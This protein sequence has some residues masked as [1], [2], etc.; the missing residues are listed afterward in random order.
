[1]RRC[2]FLA[3]LLVLATVTQAGATGLADSD[4]A[5]LR[6][7]YGL[8]R[9]STAIAGLSDEEAARLHGLIND[10][11]YRAHPLIRDD[12]V[13]RYLFEVETCVTWQPTRAGES[14]PRVFHSADPAAERGHAIA[15]R[16]CQ[17]CHLTGTPTAPSFYKLSRTGEW[18][19][20]RLA[21]AIAHGHA[22]SPITLQPEEIRDLAAY[23]A[24][25]K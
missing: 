4:Y 13:A 23:I 7:N 1:M 20:A 18:T 19:E 8:D 2:L 24:A 12:N 25:L 22:M 9:G 15:E 16:S 21:D 11:A 10:P 14:C 3:A 6:E 17:A 5:Y